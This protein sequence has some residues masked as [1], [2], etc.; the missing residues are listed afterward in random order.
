MDKVVEVALS[1]HGTFHPIHFQRVSFLCD[2]IRHLV[3]SDKT[4]CQIVNWVEV[5]FTGTLIGQFVGRIFWAVHPPGQNFAPRRGKERV[6]YLERQILHGDC[7]I[8]KW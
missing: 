1:V 6:F 5:S 7:V 8:S 3:D 2:L 4:R